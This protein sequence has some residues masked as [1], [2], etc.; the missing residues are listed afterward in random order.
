MKIFAAF[1]DTDN[2]DSDFGTGKLTRWFENELPKGCS[3]W[4][5]VR[6]QLPVLKEIPYTSHNSSA[7]AVI[8]VPDRT[9]L[10]EIV[11]RAVDHVVKHAAPGSDPGV[12]V[13]C[14]D[15][16]AIARLIDFGLRCSQ[17]V[18]TQKEAMEACRGIHLSGHGGTNDGI[19]GAAA[20]AGLCAYGR[21]GRFIEYGRLRDIP[22]V[23][24]VSELEAKG[25]MV[26]SV[27]RDATALGPHDMIDTQGWLR[28]RL[29][30]GGALLPV[31]R[32]DGQG[33]KPL[34][35]GKNRKK[36]N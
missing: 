6:H 14:E 13:A 33:W 21:S 7:C 30:D 2:I 4:G 35:A 5:V 20:A 8:E 23:V 32:N 12:C 28:P 24:S 11:S 31:R 9:I 19:I 36:E 27:D 17:R 22:S 1:D 29:W 3:L 16:P 34:L 15:D 10:S 18:V 25:I 26:I